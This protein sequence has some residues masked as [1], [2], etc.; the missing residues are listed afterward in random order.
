MFVAIA[1]AHSAAIAII[2][3]QRHRR[4]YT[5]VTAC[6]QTKKSSFSKYNFGKETR[7]EEKTRFFGTVSGM[8]KGLIHPAEYIETGKKRQH[9]FPFIG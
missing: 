8:L 9:G 2:I 4:T 5:I 6:R 3:A 1:E 7:M